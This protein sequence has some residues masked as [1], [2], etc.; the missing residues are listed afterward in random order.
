MR[1]GEAT[2]KRAARASKTYFEDQDTEIRLDLALGAPE[3]LSNYLDCI[4]AARGKER[5]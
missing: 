2:K 4:Q 3:D 1:D 5:K